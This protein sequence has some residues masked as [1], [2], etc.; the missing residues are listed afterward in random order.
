MRLL[1]ESG[2]PV[3]LA[4]NLKDAAEKVVAAKQGRLTV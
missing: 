3:I 4:Q 1:A 2:L